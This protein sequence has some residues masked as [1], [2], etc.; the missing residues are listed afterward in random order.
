MISGK[1]F[2]DG[3][4]KESSIGKEKIIKIHAEKEDAYLKHLEKKKTIGK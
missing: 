2:E 3:M 1:P 4:K